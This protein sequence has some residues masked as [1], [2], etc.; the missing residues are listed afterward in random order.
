[1][2]ENEELAYLSLL[3]EILTKGE[4]RLDRTGVGTLAVFGKTLEFDLKDNRLP[5]VSTRKI[6]PKF[7]LLELIW[8]MR[9]DTNVKYLLK[10]NC[11]IW[12]N[13]VISHTAEYDEN[14]KLVAGSIG[15]ASYG[16]MW[17]RWPAMKVVEPHEWHNKY[18]Q[19]G[20]MYLMPAPSGNMVIHKEIDQLSEAI[21]LIKKDPHSR[22]ILVSCWNPSEREDMALLPCHWSYQFVVTDA[23]LELHLNMRSSDAPVGL[24]FNITQYAFLTHVVAHLTGLKASRLVYK[25]VDVHIYSDQIELVKEQ[26]K[27]KPL[28]ENNPKLKIKLNPQEY[29]IDTLDIEDVEVTGYTSHPFIKYPVAV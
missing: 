14:G 18:A 25:G 5:I 7:P 21:R 22:R 28:K 4:K 20:W 12:N 29:S 24:V 19:A 15:S 2:K 1:M 26:L 11:P 10:H 27:R 17:R 23:G 9:G 16:A 8:F 6:N 3:D 13:W